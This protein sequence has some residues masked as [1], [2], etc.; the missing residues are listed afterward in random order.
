MPEADAPKIGREE[1]AHLAHLSRLAV[2]DDELDRFAGQL[3]TPCRRQHE[4]KP[5]P[6]RISVACCRRDSRP[7]H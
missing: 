5:A 3:E 1:V 6:H 4:G 2:T 7:L